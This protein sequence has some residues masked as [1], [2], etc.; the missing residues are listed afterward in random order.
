MSSAAVGNKLKKHFKLEKIGHG[1]TLDP[2]ATGLLI[3]LL[4][5][6]TKVSRFLLQG[7]KEYEA[8]AKLGFRTSTG[9]PTGEPLPE[10]PLPEAV[11]LETKRNH[12][13]GKILQTPPAF[14][15]IK[16]E[17]KALYE[18]ARKGEALPT[19]EPREV[20]IHSLELLSENPHSF[21]FRVAC[22]G[23]TYIRVLAED[24][25]RVSGKAAHLTSLRRTRT[26]HFRV[27]EAQT[28]EQLLQE[29]QLPLLPIERALSFLPQIPCSLEEAELIRHG[30]PRFQISLRPRCDHLGS[31]LLLQAH[32]NQA[33]RFVPLAIAE[34]TP[35]GLLL[36]R[37]FDRSLLES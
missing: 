19:I 8:E 13:L 37:V 32:A 21:S 23:G 3:F 25:A 5:E 4:G 36:E 20:E 24:W 22:S 12:F 30:N 34:L 18:Y 9:D 10:G 28:L 26:K 29:K 15:A 17:G 11:G 33:N 14:S 2:F 31:Y 7:E 6:A 1:G 35:N 16:R 27:Q